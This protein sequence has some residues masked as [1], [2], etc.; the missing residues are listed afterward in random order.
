LYANLVSTETVKTS[1]GY[2]K[3]SRK[4]ERKEAEG[5]NSET[6]QRLWHIQEEINGIG[7]TKA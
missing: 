2:V 4:S 1:S 6:G 7:I 5:T 3:T